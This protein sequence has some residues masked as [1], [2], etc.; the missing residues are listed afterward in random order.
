MRNPEGG[1]A[2]CTPQFTYKV[3]IPL[4][5]F[6]FLGKRGGKGGECGPEPDNLEDMVA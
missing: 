5:F 4:Q 6:F 2:L 3:P 1:A